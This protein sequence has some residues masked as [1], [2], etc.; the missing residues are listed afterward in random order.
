MKKIFTLLATVTMF[1]SAFAQYKTGGQKEAGYD[2]D[3]NVGYNDGG[4]KKDDKRSDSYYSFGTRERDM[5]I[6]QINREYDYKIRDVKSRLFMPRFKKEQIIRQLN[7]KRG[8]EIRRVY[9]K[10]NDHGK[11]YD[12][13]DSRRH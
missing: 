13:H 1:A 5:Q 11:R 12:D 7:D 4:F 6:A 10:F 8:E 9:A 2:K 3:N